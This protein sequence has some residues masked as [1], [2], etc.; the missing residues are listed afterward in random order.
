MKKNFATYLAMFAL[1]FLGVSCVHNDDEEVVQSP[2]ALITAFSLNNITSS[3]H[4]FTSTGDDTVVV[5]TIA[6]TAMPA[7]MSKE[8]ISSS[9][10]SAMLAKQL[11]G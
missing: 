11:A 8:F 3:Y 7:V 9:V 2:C 1:L 5:K 6:T 4:D 10:A